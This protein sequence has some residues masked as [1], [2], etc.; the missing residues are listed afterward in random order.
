MIPDYINFLL[1]GVKNQEYT[2]ATTT[3]LVNLVSKDFDNDILNKLGIPTKLFVKPQKP[4]KTLFSLKP[5]VQ[6]LVGFNANVV[7][8]A[9][10]DT[11][12]AVLATPNLDSNNLFLS[13]GT[14]SLLGAERKHQICTDQSLKLNYTNEGGFN[15]SFRFLKNIMGLWIIQNIRNEYN[16]NCSFA[17]LQ[18][19]AKEGSYFTTIIDINDKRLIAPQNMIETLDEICQESNNTIPHN[20]SEYLFMVFNSLAF[21]YS[22]TIKEIEIITNQTFEIINITGGGSQN[23]LLNELTAKHSGKIIEAG[24]VEATALGNIIVQLIAT[25]KIKTIE[26]GRKVVRN[27]FPLEVYTYE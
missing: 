15:F 16:A 17:E 23:I 19:L 5:E 3:G 1:T 25:K 21:S 7:S 24:P 18:K 13:S 22:Q 9:S 4:G 12:S 11:A 6:S 27:S 10:H 8:V 14:W 2:N 26:E 20:I